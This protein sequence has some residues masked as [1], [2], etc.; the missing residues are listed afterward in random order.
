M[1][2]RGIIGKMSRDAEADRGK[3]W[4]K[5]CTKDRALIGDERGKGTQ[6]GEDRVYSE[7]CWWRAS[8]RERALRFLSTIV[9]RSPSSIPNSR[10]ISAIA[11]SVSICRNLRGPNALK[12][13]SISSRSS[14]L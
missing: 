12:Q 4:Q 7:S 11:W 8:L 13:R 1:K 5:P 2:N 6:G 3:K 9:D 10:N 14:S